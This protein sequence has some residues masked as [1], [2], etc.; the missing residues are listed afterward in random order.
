M[1]LGAEQGDFWS[2]SLEQRVYPNGRSVGDYLN[3]G[4]S[5]D[6]FSNRRLKTK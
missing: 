6:R 5:D 2:L 3:L 1:T 4:W